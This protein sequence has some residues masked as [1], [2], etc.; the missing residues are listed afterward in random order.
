MQHLGSRGGCRQFFPA[1]PC[2]VWPWGHTAP[3]AALPTA[4]A[5]CG[6]QAGSGTCVQNRVRP[7][8][9]RLSK[10]LAQGK[11]HFLAAGSG[12]VAQVSP[13]SWLGARHGGRCGDEPRAPVPPCPAAARRWVVGSQPAVCRDRPRGTAECSAVSPVPVPSSSGPCRGRVALPPGSA[14]LPL[15]GGSFPRCPCQGCVRAPGEHEPGNLAAA[16]KGK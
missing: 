10:H 4:P 16:K 8:R 15:P 1:A 11:P 2:C 5:G 6:G 13:C 12:T 3:L 14:R 9:K 7:G